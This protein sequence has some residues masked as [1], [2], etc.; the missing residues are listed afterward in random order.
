MVELTKFSIVI[1]LITGPQIYLIIGMYNNSVES[2][3]MF[4]IAEL[5][6]QIILIFDPF[7]MRN[8]S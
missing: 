5:N 6:L 1:F 2:Y 4:K 3:L 8:Q 7:L